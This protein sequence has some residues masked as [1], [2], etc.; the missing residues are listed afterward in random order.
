MKVERQIRGCR[1]EKM[2]QYKKTLAKQIEPIPPTRE[3]SLAFSLVVFHVCLE[4]NPK[5][6]AIS[7]EAILST[8]HKFNWFDAGKHPVVF[9]VA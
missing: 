2:P 6:I 4:K 1:G 7:H 9:D 5:N 3:L 8:V